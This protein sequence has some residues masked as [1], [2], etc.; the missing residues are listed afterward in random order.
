MSFLR[1]AVIGAGHLGRIHTRLLASHEQIAVAG[2]VDP[3]PNACQSISA[4]FGVPAYSHHLD[5]A[6]QID[7]AI[8]ATPTV[9]HHQVALDLIG[10]GVHT[11]IE[12]P[13]THSVQHADALVRAAKDHNVVL[14]VCLLYTSDAADE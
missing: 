9:F 8:I 4:E 11:L 7:A 5:L 2:I 1:L 13:L 12:K 3:N 14:Q 10:Q 6:N